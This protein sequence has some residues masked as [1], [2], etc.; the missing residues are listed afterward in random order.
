MLRFFSCVTGGRSPPEEHGGDESHA[1]PRQDPRD[2]G[3]HEGTVQRD[4]EG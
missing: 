4:D 1:E 2:T 3:H